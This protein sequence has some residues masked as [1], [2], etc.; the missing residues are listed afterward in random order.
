M[1][2]RVKNRRVKTSLHRH[3][4]S[5]LVTIF[6]V[7]WQS[8]SVNA[9][10]GLVQNKGCFTLTK[11]GRC[12]YYRCWSVTSHPECRCTAT[13]CMIL[14]SYDITYILHYYIFHVKTK[15]NQCLE[16]ATRSTIGYSRCQITAALSVC[17]RLEI[18]AAGQPPLSR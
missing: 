18:L 10:N 15:P 12:Q 9:K 13:L 4:L 14:S 6:Y 5:L 16:R 1:H 2:E 11:V 17:V 7:K 3:Y 8:E